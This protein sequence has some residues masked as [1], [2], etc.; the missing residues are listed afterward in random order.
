MIW[1][2]RE[3]EKQKSTGILQREH[4]PLFSPN[5]N[6]SD[7]DDLKVKNGKI[8]GGTKSEIRV[9]IGNWKEE[10]SLASWETK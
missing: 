4:L 3:K 1:L 9:S 10:P 8:E 7:E 6:V 2:T 5:K